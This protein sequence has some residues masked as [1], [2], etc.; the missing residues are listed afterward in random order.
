MTNPTLSQVRKHLAL[1][2]FVSYPMPILTN[3]FRHTIAR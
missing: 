2:N 1:K 3:F